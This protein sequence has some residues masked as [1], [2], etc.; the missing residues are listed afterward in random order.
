MKSKREKERQGKTVRFKDP[1]PSTK[2]SEQKKINR[3]ST[4]VLDKKD[5]P[6]KN[7]SSFLFRK[8]SGKGISRRKK[9]IKKSSKRISPRQKPYE[10]KSLNLSKLRMIQN[11]RDSIGSDSSR[12]SR[13]ST[14]SL[15]TKSCGSEIN[16][17]RSFHLLDVTERKAEKLKFM[18]SQ[19][20]SSLLD[21]KDGM[22]FI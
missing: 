9:E 3:L 13:Q 14:S 22:L 5:K 12:S 20:G 7:T 18:R 17:E 4:D 16:F 21:S 8:K 15:S 11:S 19:S 2:S 1:A 10:K 6:N